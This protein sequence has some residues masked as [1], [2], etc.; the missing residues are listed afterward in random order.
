MEGLGQHPIVRY[1]A[2]DHVLKALPGDQGI[3][4]GDPRH[5]PHHRVCHDPRVEDRSR[6]HKVQHPY[7]RALAVG[8]DPCVLYHPVSG[9]DPPPAAV[10][11]RIYSG[12]VGCKSDESLVCRQ[13][14]RPGPA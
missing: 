9:L 7:D 3:L 12:N 4:G 6:V 1:A 2:L 10:L 14:L 11:V 13:L 5:D 8:P